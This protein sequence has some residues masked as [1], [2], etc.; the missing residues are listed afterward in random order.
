VDP[1][2]CPT[3]AEL[4]AF[5][6]GELSES[7][8]E[9]VAEHLESCPECESAARALD[10]VA[11]P[12]IA[13]LQH[14]PSP[15]SWPAGD[16]RYDAGRRLLGSVPPY[17]SA[18]L[19][20]G[21]I[22]DYE[23]L[24]RI[25]RGGMGAVYKARQVALNRLVALKILRDGTFADPEELARFR[26]EALALARLQHP[27]I[28]QIHEIGEHQGQPFFSLEF[29][30]GGN[31]AQK[32][33][34]RPLSSRQAAQLVELL[35]LAVHAAHERGII[36]RDLKPANV[37][38]VRSDPL[39]G[40]RL[41]DGPEEAG[42]FEPKI[43]DFG[44]AKRLD[45]DRRQ[46]GSGTI[47]GT[48][49]YMA[50]EQA[51][52]K[53][54]EAGP[55]ADVYALGAVLY[56]VL[57]GRPPFQGETP[58]DTLEQV[59]SLEPVPPTR[60][61]P[62]VP[63]DLETICLKCLHKEPHKRYASAEALAEDLRR[64]RAG[65]PIRARP[66]SAWERGVR[67]AKRRPG[68]AALVGVN[69]LTI[70][71]LAVTVGLLFAAY[72]EAE[73][74]RTAT[75]AERNKAQRGWKFYRNSLHEV[76]NQLKTWAGETKESKGIGPEPL[77]QK[78][79]E[80]S[81]DIYDGF[82]QGLI[83]PTEVEV[84]RGWTNLW[85]GEV[86][87]ALR[88]HNE[89]EAAYQQARTIF[90]RLVADYPGEPAYQHM[91]AGVLDKLGDFYCDTSQHGRA[92]SVHREELEISERLVK[93]YPLVPEYQQVWASNYNNRGRVYLATG[94]L[95]LARQDFQESL[96]I[97]QD[98]VKAFPQ[99]PEYN[100]QLAISHH[101]LAVIYG[102][103]NQNDESIAAYRKALEITQRL[104]ENY[105]DES[106]YQWVLACV[107][108]NLGFVYEK[109]SRPESALGSYE[110]AVR[111]LQD[112]VH[113]HPQV[114]KYQERLESSYWNRAALYYET[115]RF[116]LAKRAFQQLRDRGRDRAND[117]PLQSGDAVHLAQSDLHIGHVSR[118]FG[119]YGDAVRSY[120][121]VIERLEA[122]LRTE[123]LQPDTRHILV[124]AYCGRAAV[125][126][127][128]SRPTEQD[129]RRAREL[130]D[131]SQGEI[132]ALVSALVL[133]C[134]GGHAKATDEAEK[135]VS[136]DAVTGSTFYDAA[137]VYASAATAARRD[138][139]LTPSRREDQAAHYAH[140]AVELLQKARGAGFFTDPFSVALLKTD[141]D[142]NPLRARDDFQKLLAE[143]EA[144][145][146]T[147][148]K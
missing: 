31:L 142:L 123:P 4:S 68:V 10:G 101:N 73:G 111:I 56:E 84:E 66:I 69:G 17:P 95:N 132:V 99:V 22:G 18:E 24:E 134:G 60:L 7:Q 144:T 125:S 82:P 143:L 112:L 19:P 33:N 5:N 77:R 28:V 133:A 34:G 50:P 23:I 67:W 127:K 52:G 124:E 122:V 130:D 35:T 141:T 146:K 14:A 71:G 74:A 47:M 49:S 121:E 113:R 91:L 97:N 57:T 61:Q 80:T 12:V 38:L 13:A 72:R 92:E 2:D 32:L 20:T 85:L 93:A 8:L 120:T 9:Q 126:G 115:G 100:W 3:P 53:N 64:F 51:A 78:F 107:G 36:H 117:G 129:L 63:R 118:N 40:V 55:L 39:H 25:G 48:P 87:R 136:R 45:T 98:L 86:H 102:I 41:E 65:E 76:L 70:L 108:T 128:L 109:A 26:N 29:V 96:Q 79:L 148:A 58:L 106:D 88:K 27:H 11:D 131:K 16:G 30:D 43:T 83:H 94:R 54:R 147:R 114:P 119:Q 62:K 110:Q 145:E 116:D 137:C 135:L 103:Q 1:T 44:L 37:L 6:W 104:V 90:G 46:T 140:R 89:A 81:L 75:L 59:R 138:D 105:R 15:L 42:Y 139:K 21:R